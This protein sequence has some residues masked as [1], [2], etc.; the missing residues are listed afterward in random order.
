MR[1]KE[2]VIKKSL[3]LFN[4]NTYELSTTNSIAKE[5]E[6]LEGSLWYHFNTK[7]D[8]V[9]THINIFLD[10]YNSKKNHTATDSHLLYIQGLFSVY[11]DIWNYRYLFRDSF[12]KIARKSPNLYLRIIEINRSIDQWLEKSV[13]HAKEIGIL[14]IDDSDIENIVEISLIIGRYWFDFS[15]KRY[16]NESNDYLRKKGLNLLIK[17]FYPYLSANSKDLINSIYKSI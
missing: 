1:T 8:I 13:I 6:I 14:K 7:L 15:K 16:S 12:E 2:I 11:E 3:S 10:S 5:S 17:S 9:S 4:K